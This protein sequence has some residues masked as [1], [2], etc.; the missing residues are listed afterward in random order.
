MFEIVAD[1]LRE[2]GRDDI[3]V[4]GCFDHQRRLELVP[5]GNFPEMGCARVV[6]RHQVTRYGGW[7]TGVGIPSELDDLGVARI[8]LT[9][10]A[11]RR[12]GLSP[13]RC[14]V[15]CY[16]RTADSD[17]VLVGFV[18][19]DFPPGA[20]RCSQLHEIQYGVTSDRNAPRVILP[21]VR[22]DQDGEAIPLRKV[23]GGESRGVDS[24]EKPRARIVGLREVRVEGQRQRALR[25]EL[26]KELNTHLAS[27]RKEERITLVDRHNQQQKN[28]HKNHPNKNK[29]NNTKKQDPGA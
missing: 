7:L 8:R 5:I 26:S 20:M 14:V 18:R 24:E 3:P 22:L 16:I 10:N 9:R 23:A 28:K 11:S 2:G 4:L 27:A 19:L 15:E 29:K 17:R 25:S 1:R 13:T 6:Y 21:G 12:R